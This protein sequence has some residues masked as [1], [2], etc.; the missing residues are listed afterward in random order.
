MQSHVTQDIGVNKNIPVLTSTVGIDVDDT[1]AIW[2]V[3]PNQAVWVWA[4][5]DVLCHKRHGDHHFLD[6]INGALNLKKKKKKVKRWNIKFYFCFQNTACIVGTGSFGESTHVWT[7]VNGKNDWWLCLFVWFKGNSLH[8]SPRIV[9]L[10]RKLSF[11][12]AMTSL[13]WFHIHHHKPY[14]G[15]PTVLG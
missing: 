12:T 4:V 15:S 13:T 6:I 9:H 10:S 11:L 5:R 1:D 7:F 14:G 8:Q 2:T 3:F